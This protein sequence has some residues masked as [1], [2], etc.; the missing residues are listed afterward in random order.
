MTPPGIVRA[1]VEADPELRVALKRQGFLARDSR[2]VKKAGLKQ[3][4]KTPQRACARGAH[5]ASLKPCPR[6]KPCLR[7]VAWSK[8]TGRL[9]RPP[10]RSR[11]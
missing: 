2:I 1:L 9:E 5:R 4:R 3:S 11:R 6:L 7:F 8:E 10:A